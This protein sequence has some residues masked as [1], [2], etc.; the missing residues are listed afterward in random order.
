LWNDRHSSNQAEEFSKV[1]KLAVTVVPS[2]RPVIRQDLPDVI[3]P[4][5]NARNRAPLEEIQ[6][7]HGTGRPILVGTR[8]V[9]HSEALSSQLMAVG[10]DHRVLNAK[11]DEAEAEII[12]QAG[13]LGVVTISTNMAGRGTDIFPGG[14]PPKDREK[15]VA[16]GGL[17]VIGT[18][19][20]Q[21]RRIDNQ[22][23]GKAGRQGDPGTSRFFISVNDDLLVR[24]GISENP[25]LR[26][27]AAYS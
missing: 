2:N 18:T 22:L 10:I 27:R 7:V 25:D 12:A 4:D 11:N 17:Y 15:V 13:A 6:R 3:Y 1:Y 20:H 8:S 26:K 23:R 16:L 21:A 24:F 19:R 14:N 9:E 5:N